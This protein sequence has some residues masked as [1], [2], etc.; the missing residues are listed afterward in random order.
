[1]IARS[2]FVADD[3]LRPA[4]MAK[5]TAVDN[6][7]IGLVSLSIVRVYGREP[8]RP[9][10]DRKPRTSAFENLIADP[11]GQRR[12]R[13]VALQRCDHLSGGVARLHANLHSAVW[14]E[15]PRIATRYGRDAD[16]SRGATT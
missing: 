10:L 15:L 12:V 2:S 3:M 11:D 8:E 13:I 9:D 14:I 4:G 1:M 7:V 16:L 5:V 6:H